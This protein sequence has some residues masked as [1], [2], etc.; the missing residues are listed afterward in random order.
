MM[1][2]NLKKKLVE[3]LVDKEGNQTIR[4]CTYKVQC[5]TWANQAV[6]SNILSLY[7]CSNIY[8][9]PIGGVKAEGVTIVCTGHG[10]LP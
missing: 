4:I 8:P 5:N 7:A 10:P 1:K 6:T 2:E 9:Y 3:K